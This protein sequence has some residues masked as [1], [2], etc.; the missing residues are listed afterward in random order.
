MG[1]VRLNVTVH[2]NTSFTIYWKDDL[3][4]TYVCF[5]VEWW[6]K[7]QKVTHVSF[8]ESDRNHK[9]LHPKGL[10]PYQRYSITLHT[11]PNKD[12]CNMKHIN[13]SESTYSTARF[14]SVQGCKSDVLF[15]F[16]PAQNATTE[17]LSFVK[18]PS[19]LPQTSAATM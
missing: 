17:F 13:N 1:D 8:Y 14:Y 6:K 10:E 3:I 16:L 4:K 9:T 12:T 7:G 2:S 11:R 18:L 19:A 5:S 15:M